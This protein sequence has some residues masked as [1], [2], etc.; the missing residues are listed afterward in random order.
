MGAL[1][2]EE[3]ARDLAQSSICNEKPSSVK[4]D[5]LLSREVLLDESTREAKDIL[6]PTFDPFLTSA[7]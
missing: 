4:R 7:Q 6:L 5:E 2:F 3:T 1:G